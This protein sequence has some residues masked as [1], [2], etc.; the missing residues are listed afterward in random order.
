MKR[1][2]LFAGDTWY[3]SGGWNDFVD[4]YDTIADAAFR[5]MGTGDW[6]HIVDLATGQITSNWRDYVSV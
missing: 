1:Y 2:A 4:T 6:F 3:P 5:G